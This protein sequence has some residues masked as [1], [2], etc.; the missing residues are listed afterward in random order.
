MYKWVAILTGSKN[1]LKGF[2]FF[3]GAALLTMLGFR[4]AILAMATAL[5][6]VFFIGFLLLK[7][8]MGKTQFKPKFREIFAK[9]RNINY[10]SAA[11]LFLFGSR[12]VWFVV[13]LPVYFQEV[14]HWSHYRVGSV[15]RFNLRFGGHFNEWQ[16]EISILATAHPTTLTAYCCLL[17]IAYCLAL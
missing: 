7:Q 12:D 3:L 4:G 2:G 9:S 11:R 16:R 8:D 10:L 15:S 6:L 14:L 1:A 13:A 5:V 17:P